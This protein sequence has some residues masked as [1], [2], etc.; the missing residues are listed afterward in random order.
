MTNVHNARIIEF[1]Q[2]VPKSSVKRKSSDRVLSLLGHTPRIT[3]M[4]GQRFF[5]FIELRFF[6]HFSF[7]R[8]NSLFTN[9]KIL[10]QI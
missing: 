6:K 7:L 5:I 1:I 2:G 3:P 10:Q 8:L 4:N 9:Q